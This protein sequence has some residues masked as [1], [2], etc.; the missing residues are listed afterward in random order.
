MEA[1]AG[2][3]LVHHSLTIHRA[4]PNR[5]DRQRKSIGFIFYSEDVEIDEEAHAEYKRK[6]D[7][8]LKEEG[9]I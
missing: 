2:D 7:L 4:N 8:V 6:L 9:K 3:I 1:G 5:S